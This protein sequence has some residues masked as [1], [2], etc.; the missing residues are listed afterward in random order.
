VRLAAARLVRLVPTLVLLFDVLVRLVLTPASLVRL[1]AARLVPTLVLLF[2]VLVHAPCE[3][4]LLV[5]IGEDVVHPLVENL[6]LDVDVAA[7]TPLVRLV[8]LFDEGATE[9]TPAAPTSNIT[10]PVAAATMRA[11]TSNITIPVAAATILSSNPCWRAERPVS[12]G[13]G[14]YAAWSLAVDVAVVARVVS[15][16]LLLYLVIG[17]L[18]TPACFNS[19]PARTPDRSPPPQLP[20]QPGARM[21]RVLQWHSPSPSSRRPPCCPAVHLMFTCMVVMFVR[22]LVRSRSLSLAVG[23]DEPP[24][25][26]L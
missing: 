18:A 2:D 13:G 20:M 17:I 23:R 26:G 19:I 11:P 4:A 21:Q 16:V 9:A 15:F 22:F 12:C 8:L 3:L 5:A 24:Q 14:A 7:V 1:A 25:P 10:I 6:L